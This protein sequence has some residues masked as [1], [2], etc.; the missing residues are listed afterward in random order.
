MQYVA[1]GGG[2]GEMFRRSSLAGFSMTS[3]AE[4]IVPERESVFH[5]LE[6]TPN[7]ALSLLSS[8]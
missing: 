5:K 6:I 7:C 1:D 3:D 2:D 8:R 4:L